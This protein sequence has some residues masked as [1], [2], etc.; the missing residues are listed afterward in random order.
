MSL[1]KEYKIKLPDN[2]EVV[3]DEDWLKNLKQSLD[4]EFGRSPPIPVQREAPTPPPWQVPSRFEV[5][6]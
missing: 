2:T 4:V 3:V 6:S 1:T 5:T